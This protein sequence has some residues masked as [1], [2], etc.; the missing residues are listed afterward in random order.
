MHPNQGISTLLNH[1]REGNN[2]EF[3]HLTP[4]FQ[5]ATFEFPDV[6]TGQAIEEGREPGYIYTRLGNPNTRQLADK[7]ALLEGLDL[8]RA[9]PGREASEVIAGQV[10]SSGMGAIAAALFA[11]A[12]EGDTVLAQRSLYSNTYT[13]LAELAP[14]WGI[15]VVW[16]DG[17][18]P[19]AWERVFQE[20]R[21]AVMAY[22]ESPVNPTMALT[23]LSAVA[24]IAHRFGSRLFVDNTFA[25]PYCQ[26][27]LTMGADIV[28][29]STTKFLSGQGAVVGG[30]LIST[31]IDF[32]H[33]PVQ[34]VLTLVG[35]NASPFEAWLVNLGLRSFELRMERHCA[36]A[37]RIARHLEEHSAVE[38]VH[39][40]GLESHPQHELATRQM[41]CYGGMLS[42]ELRGGYEAGVRML[43]VLKTMTLAVSLGA[44][45]TLIQHPASM[46]HS[47]VP[48]EERHRMGLTDG[49]VR[50]SVGIE[51]VEDLIADLD[52]AL[53]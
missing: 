16:V 22:A 33:G 13:L 14:R 50:L 11:V 24:E 28:L 37:L 32:V 25:T 5:N 47:A 52:Q 41:S 44:M 26:R 43:D 49:L 21:D 45:D 46:T 36:N 2:P 31:D 1:Y 3:A 10:F 18:D 6:M 34:D 48:S 8:L 20:N 4:I 7:I 29:H 35:A 42:F 38:A 39:Y 27:P 9:D 12:K 19:G 23:D 17:N 51:N 15:R 53:P 40:P 30:A